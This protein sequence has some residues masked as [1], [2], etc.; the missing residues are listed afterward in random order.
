MGTHAITKV[1]DDAGNEILCMY[2]QSDGY[3]E[4]HGNELAEFLNSRVMVQGIRDREIDGKTVANGMGCLAA[5]L[6]WHF[7]RG[8]PGEFY[9]QAPGKSS[10]TYTYL[11]YP[12]RLEA[13]AHDQVFYSGPWSDWKLPSEEGEEVESP[14]TMTV[15]L[16]SG[17]SVA[18]AT[19]VQNEI[20]GIKA[21]TDVVVD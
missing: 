14:K 9:L 20:L 3:P 17:L 12:T 18:E 16:K 7:K 21:V 19:A 11:V 13:R 4:G 6:V 15:T 8:E 1:F 10:Q 2:R 5:Q